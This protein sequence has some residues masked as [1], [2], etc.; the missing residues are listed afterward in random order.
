MDQKKQL[1]QLKNKREEI[2]WKASQEL[3]GLGCLFSA[4]GP[5]QLEGS[6]IFGI[7]LIL[8]RISDDLQAISESE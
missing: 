7:G 6:D 5:F 3:K 1:S 4:I 8:E 2:I